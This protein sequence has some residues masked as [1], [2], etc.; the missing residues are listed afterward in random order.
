MSSAMTPETILAALTSLEE[1]LPPLVGLKSWKSI[2]KEFQAHMHRLQHSSDPVDREISASELVNIVAPYDDARERLREEIYLQH[3]RAVLRDTMEKE[4]PPIAAAIGVDDK[5]ITPSADVAL[6]SMVTEPA[7]SGAPKDGVRLIKIKTCG[8]GG[9]KTI[10]IRNLHLDLGVL[11]DLGAGV[12]MTVSKIV[13]QPH[14]IIIVAGVLLTIRSL[15]KAMT[16][17]LSEQ[18]ASV[19]WGLIGAQNAS[20]RADKTAIRK[21]TN[22]ERTQYGLSALN[23]NQVTEAL[24]RLQALKCVKVSVQ[25][26]E[27]WRI[28]ENYTIEY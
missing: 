21:H 6:Q 2:E 10:K 1:E 9:G 20:I 16:V 25:K 13:G 5:V 19:F 14:P 17:S 12:T 24:K 23:E 8:I 18:E 28:V 11:I 7:K 4:L 22:S 15:M 26:P 27:T 3:I